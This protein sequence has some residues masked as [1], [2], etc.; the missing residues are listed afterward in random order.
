MKSR[1]SDE[2][3]Q[4]IT[5]RQDVETKVKSWALIAKTLQLLREASVKNYLY[6]KKSQHN[7]KE[8]YIE[9]NNVVISNNSDENSSVEVVNDETIQNNHDNLTECCLCLDNYGT[10]QGF[11][12]RSNCKHQFCINCLNQY[13]RTEIQE[14]RVDIK[15]PQCPSPMHPDDIEHLAVDGDDN[16]KVNLYHNLMVQRVLV[17]DPDTRWCPTPNCTFGVI[18]TDCQSCPK[19]DCQKEGC[20]VSFCY[21]CRETWE[22]NHQCGTKSQQQMAVPGEEINLRNCPRCSVLVEKMD[23]GSCNHMN[24][25]V[26]GC[27]FCWLC[28]KEVTSVHYLLPSG[29]TFWAEKKWS[30]RKKILW[31][32]G[33]LIGAP[34]GIGLLAGISAPVIV[35]GIPVDVGRKLYRARDKNKSRLRRTMIITSG[36]TASAL[37]SPIVASIAVSAGVTSLLGYTYTVVPI[38]LYKSIVDEDR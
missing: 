20:N 3:V 26:C 8:V 22:D 18:A 4:V 36:V 9:A 12:L 14:R 28:M 1:L 34:V 21:H 11:V 7:V 27:E 6:T 16:T 29:C 19:I 2:G 35:F 37:I 32:L 23:D 15:C 10:D 5:D 30:K 33:T 24:C 31:Q 17:N 25:S 13:V 38:S